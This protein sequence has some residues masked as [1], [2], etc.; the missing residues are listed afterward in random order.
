MLGADEFGFATAPLVVEGCIMMRKCHLNTCPVGIATQDPELRKRFSGQ[1][2]HVVNFFFFVAEEAREIMASLGIR[3]FNDLIGRSDLLDK[4]KGIEHWK[5]NGLDFS[6]IFYQPEMGNG[7]ARYN[8]EGQD[9]GLENA[10]DNELIKKSITA[11]KDKS[12]IEFNISITNVN[13]TVGTMLSHEVAK[14][15]GNAGLLEDSIKINLHGT[16]G[17]S[18]GAFLAKGITFNLNGEGNDYVG[19]GLCGGKIIIKPPKEFNGLAEENIIVGNTTMYGATSG[20]TYFKGVGGER[21][22]VRNSGASAVIEGVGNH[23]CEYMTG[24]T[25]VILGRTGQNFAAGM[26]G[27][28]A[29]VYD[30]NKTFKNYCN[31]SMVT[32]DKVEKANIETE[33]PQ[34]LNLADEIILK[35]LIEK[36]CQ[37]TESNIAKKILN[38]WDTELENFVKVMPIEYKRALSEMKET[39]RKEVA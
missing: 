36:H 21:F 37:Y 10:L 33:T 1:P 11:I 26:S 9:H 39:K 24:G 38:Q 14:R 4:Q 32:L 31:L 29:Y 35:T 28:V 17:Q 7:V 3:K 2:E 27:G 25:V 8:T 20:E 18:F 6:K 16:A 23:G 22:C 5:I 12:N 13:R 30:P 19:K 34:H 15:Y